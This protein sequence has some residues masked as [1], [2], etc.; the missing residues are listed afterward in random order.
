MSNNI[1]KDETK[2]VEDNK[3]DTVSV[4][5]T[6][7]DVAPIKKRVTTLD[8]I[9]DG[10]EEVEISD[11]ERIKQIMQKHADENPLCELDKKK[12]EKLKHIMTYTAIPFLLL[13][14]VFSIFNIGRIRHPLSFL[15]L[16]IGLG[17]MAVFYYIRHINIKKC[18]CSVCQTQAKTTLQFSI[19]WGIIAL[20]LLGAFIYFMIVPQA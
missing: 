19:L 1:E 4:D 10:E 20:A 18:A 12:D 2:I 17:V 15:S 11:E 13:S 16:S 6:A 9:E 3:T 5:Q 8:D 7:E 14:I